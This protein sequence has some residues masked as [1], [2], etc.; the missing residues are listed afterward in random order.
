MAWKAHKLRL[1]TEPAQGV[2]S[3]VKRMIIKYGGTMLGFRLA[4]LAVDAL[5]AGGTA[6]TKAPARTPKTMTR[7]HGTSTTCT[8]S[9]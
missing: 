1:L 5:G 6:I 3:G 4:S 7:R 8:I 2:D 9:A